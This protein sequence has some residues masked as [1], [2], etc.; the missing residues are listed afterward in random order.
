MLLASAP[1]LKVITTSRAPLRIDGEIEYPLDSLPEADAVE[2]L[3]TE[4]ARVRPDFT[5]DDATREICRRLDGLPLAL[6]LAASRLR[7]LGSQALL[8][9]LD[10]G[11]RS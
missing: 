10:L 1:R 11:C 8:E 6:E 7:S 3:T 4:R 9:R 2:L 5:P